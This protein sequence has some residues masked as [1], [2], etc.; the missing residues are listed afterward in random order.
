MIRIT[1]PFWIQTLCLLFGV[2]SSSLYAATAS[3]SANK[4]V[5]D[6][7]FQLR[8]T[9][10]EQLDADA[11]DFSA[12]KQN[13]YMGRPNFGSYTNYVN[14]VKSV[15]SEWTITLAPLKTGTITIPAFQ[16]GSDST[17]PI[18]MTVTT[19]ANAP[20]PKDLVE[21]QVRINRQELYPGESAQLNTRL[22]IKAELRRLKD[23][24]I[25][26]PDIE[27]A[28]KQA[29]ELKPKGKANQYQSI[30]NGVEVTVVDQNY[31]LI[32]R[33]TGKYIIN[34]PQLK[35]AIIA[36]QTAN[37]N[38]RL[39]PITTQQKLLVIDVLDKPQ[40]YQGT[41]LP[42]PALSLTQTWRD[43][44]GKE[45]DGEITPLTVQVGSPL[46]REITLTA[47]GVEQT[48]L[49]DL[50]ITYPDQLR[51]Y[52]EKPVFRKEENRVI[53]TIKQVLIPK[54]A[55]EI[56]LP[57]VSLPWWN[58]RE[59]RQATAKVKGIQL[60]VEESDTPTLSIAS[61]Q[62]VDPVKEAANTNTVIVNSPGYWPY[63]TALFAILWLLFTGL[64][65]KAKR[66]KP[67]NS[68]TAAA[69]EQPVMTQLIRAIRQNDTIQAQTLY[70]QW[71]ADHQ[72]QTPT[73]IRDIEQEMECMMAAT[74]APSGIKWDN[75]KLLGLLKK[76]A[77]I[78]PERHTN[79]D[80]AAL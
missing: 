36:G 44:N 80:L 9:A 61:P 2:F 39:I 32:A 71:K 4:V 45:L 41:W 11:I 74:Y 72:G 33:Q 1:N 40:S 13:F 16:V 18:Q 25:I 55:G 5:K 21:F 49:P 43:E 65:V 58:T 14:G 76:A 29:I 56:T 24:K 17:A 64:W 26:Q 28:D 46:T 53:M 6:E 31:D 66:Q 19:D 69:E 60:T 37:G 34:G 27:G 22:L 30:L 79:D 57:E 77:K 63:L 48:Q 7:V 59:K 3:V 62:P 51:R 68:Q 12:L 52:E 38:A 35:G 15:R 8:V 78:R 23:A 70:R 20:K 54:Q 73:L 50:K 10:E 42:S 75:K 47:E 67:R